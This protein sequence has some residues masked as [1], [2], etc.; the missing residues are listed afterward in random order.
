MSENSHTP[1]IAALSPVFSADPN[2]THFC[3]TLQGQQKLEQLGQ[4]LAGSR[5]LVGLYV[6]ESTESDY[7]SDDAQYGRVV[8]LVRMLPMPPGQTVHAYKSGCLEY[9]RSQLVDRWPVGWPS[10]VV[11]HSPHGG[12]VLRHA[13]AS[14]LQVYDY[15]S[16]AGQFLQG[17]I[18]LGPIPALR[19]QLLAE[20]QHQ[21]ARNPRTQLR[22]F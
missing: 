2:G 7:N 20:I 10:E 12:P 6:P 4:R 15:G 18:D 13:V 11:F 16:W 8:A 5:T 3:V 17:P 9:R 21:I 1:L 14:A 19:R 22:P